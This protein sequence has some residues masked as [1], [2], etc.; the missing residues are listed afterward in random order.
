MSAAD[1]MV[2]SLTLKLR[3]QMSGGIDEIKGS[4]NGLKGTL[5][6]LNT[7]LGELKDVLATLKAPVNLIS[8]LD[9]AKTA[10]GETAAA[11]RN[12]G[13]AAIEST[14]KI[15]EMNDA[16]RSNAGGGGGGHGG[17]FNGPH[18][19]GHAVDWFGGAL[20]G[21]MGLG[22]IK[23]FADFQNTELHITITDKLSGAGAIAEQN[24]LTAMLDPLALK[25][26]T[27]SADLADSYLFLVTTGMK[28]ALI[29]Q[30]MPAL[31]T[32]STAYNVPVSEMT[33]AAFTLSENLKIGPQQMQQALATLAYAGKLGHFNLSDFGM[34]LPQLGGQMSLLGMNGMQGEDVAA[35]ALEIG[36]RNTGTSGEA[37]TNLQDLLGY[38][39]SPMG[40][41]M[42]DQTKKMRDLMGAPARRLFE[43]YHIQPLDMPAYLNAERAKGIDPI[44][45][46]AD[47]FHKML[48]GVSSPTDRATIVGSFL[49]NQQARNG[50]LSLV[51]Y[52]DDFHKDQAQLAGVDPKTVQ[53]DFTTAMQGSTSQVRQFDEEMTQLER[54]LG[55]G[56]LPLLRGTNDVLKPLLGYITK[57]NGEYQIA[58]V[59]LGNLALGATA[60]IV[61][62]KTLTSVFGSGAGLI[63][64][65]LGVTKVA[66]GGAT[67]AEAGVVARIAGVAN[68]YIAA[69]AAVVVAAKAIADAT[70]K[71]IDAINANT[72]AKDK[73]S[74]VDIAGGI[75]GAGV[76]PAHSDPGHGGWGQLGRMFGIP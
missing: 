28:K 58:G 73:V 71:S 12:I 62:F 20:A 47:Y 31:A 17:G 55:Q 67:V 26:S 23:S 25:T 33:Q 63:G 4:F 60:S 7:V 54:D 10:A 15:K 5:D 65:I 66:A 21:Y 42:F 70:N 2:A 57:L 46:L 11:V 24:R 43:K 74:I 49:H 19:A 30:I 32:T 1:D 29:D 3:D 72:A 48:A 51:Q 35:A 45:A 69:T 22:A 6:G 37:A 44:N 36:R 38:I 34:F 39:T 8:G 14:T 9:D 61:A 76:I 59:G 41:R 68:P 64:R 53:T 50:L 75:A 56:L 40:I 52:Y 16:M 13:A 18:N 27:S